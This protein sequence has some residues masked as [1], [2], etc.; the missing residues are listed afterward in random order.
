MIIETDS[1]GRRNQTDKR[2]RSRLRRLCRLA[3][4]AACWT[5]L[6]VL[7]AVWLTMRFTGDRMWVGTVLLMA[8]RWPFA[9]PL[10]VLWPWALIAWRRQAVVAAALSTG[11]VLF[12]V[13]GFQVSLSSAGSARGDLRLVTCNGHRQRLDPERFA[14]F[15]AQVNPDVIAIQGWSEAGRARLFGGSDW[16]VRTVGELLVASRFPIQGVSPLAIT[17]AANAFKEGQGAAAIFELTTPHG[18]VHL[19]SLHL[20]SPHAGLLAFTDDS[21]E[22]LTG[23]IDRRWKE[24]DLLLE[25][26]ERVQGPLLIAGDFNTTDD[27]P[28]FREHWGQFADAFTQRGTGFGY[29]YIIGHTQLRIDHIL[30]ASPSEFVRCWV[31][32][33]V[34]SPHRPLVADVICR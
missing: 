28:I 10:A 34:G 6:L 14:A 18:P 27:S 17:E 11:T 15:I 25:I 2:P 19:I 16:N 20:A 13:M 4:I 3:L 24:S 23:N 12:L 21:G 29:T 26:A 33:N 1:A 7:I 22:T 32:P 8:P 9:L 5:Y 30:T 31:G